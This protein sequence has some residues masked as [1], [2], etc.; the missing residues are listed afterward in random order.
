MN[1]RKRDCLYRCFIDRVKLEATHR[2]IDPACYFP[3]RGQLQVVQSKEYRGLGPVNAALDKMS[4]TSIGGHEECRKLICAICL[5]EAGQKCTRTVS[6]N[7]VKLIKE[8]VS[9]S[10]NVED[11]RFATGICNGCQRK[12]LKIQTDS[13]III[14]VSSQFCVQLPIPTRSKVSS[15]CTCTICTRA[16]LNG[17]AWNKFRKDCKKIDSVALNK[18]EKLCPKCFSKIYPGSSHSEEA[19]QSKNT[20][21]DNLSNIDPKILKAALKK[22]NVEVVEKKEIPKPGPSHVYTNDDVKHLKKITGVSGKTVK[23]F[24]QFIRVKEGPGYVEPHVRENM[25]RDKKLFE[26]YFSLKKEK[27]NESDSVPAMDKEV[28]LFFCHDPDG[29]IETECEILGYSPHELTKKL[30]IDSGKGSLKLT[31]SMRDQTEETPRKK[32]RVTHK[33]TVQAGV[34]ILQYLVK[35]NSCF[36]LLQGAQ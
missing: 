8:Y 24:M 13:K 3:H 11:P 28:P 31:L 27:F 35:K 18:G 34:Y 2:N 29:F 1:N 30:G 7:E 17:G 4:K 5:T 22:Q 26:P 36:W 15:N 19:C 23:T 9:E 20:L 21:I 16:R 33:D 14:R 32:S 25:A 12:L 10:Y 6:K